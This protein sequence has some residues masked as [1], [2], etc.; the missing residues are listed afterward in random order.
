MKE[1]DLC[2]YVQKV[3]DL[4]ADLSRAEQEIAF[5][6]GSAPEKRSSTTE[7]EEKSREYES[8]IKE[9]QALS[10]QLAESMKES[11]IL[12]GVGTFL[13]A[14]I[15]RLEEELRKTKEENVWNLRTVKSGTGEA[16]SRIS[17]SAGK[18]E[19]APGVPLANGQE[20]ILS[21]SLKEHFPSALSWQSQQQVTRNFLKKAAFSLLFLV[22]L[23]VTAGIPL[24]EDIY[25]SLTSLMSRKRTVPSGTEV[26]HWAEGIK[27][28]KSGEYMISLTFLNREAI[29]VLGLSDK[30]T[31]ASTADNFY[32]FFELKA[33]H[34]CIPDSFLS[35]FEKEVSFLD[36]QGSLIPLNVSEDMGGEK[37]AFY[38]TEVC[39]DKS[40]V[41]D[42]KSVISARK[43]AQ[44]SA[45]AINGLNAESPIILR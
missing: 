13:S 28:L 25:N 30:V 17:E 27:Q 3:K 45:L 39:G 2:T 5:L 20:E 40:G 37:K 35:S 31:D 26:T 8:L 7:I 34:G 18:R 36:G 38:K 6:Q 41:V 42:L 22:L 9:Q 11:R 1:R 33:E 23:V 32:A 10:D 14:E 29:S 44:I 15:K 16:C 21:D 4:E 12:R 24:R 19:H 43:N